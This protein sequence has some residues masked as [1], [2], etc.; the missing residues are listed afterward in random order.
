M[1][2]GETVLENIKRI[3]KAI[4][5]IEKNLTKKIELKEIASESALSEYHFHRLFHIV[6]GEA[7]G[8]YIRKRRL[9]QAAKSLSK[10]NKR[11]IDVA[12]DYGY[13]SSD[14][15]SRAFTKQFGFNPKD[16]K[17]NSSLLI[18]FP[19]PELTL[20][21]LN[22]INQGVSMEPKIIEKPEMKLVGVV[23]YGDNKSDEIP[24]F[25]NNHFSEVSSIGSRIDKNGCFGFCFHN[26]DYIKKGLFH[27]MP[28]VEVEN[29]DD[30][31][32]TAVAK[33]VPAHKYAVFTHT[34]DAEKL[35]ETY[36][37]IYGTWFPHKK[38]KKNES[39]DFEYYT[40]DEKGKSII[41]LHIPI[42]DK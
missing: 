8:S 23:Y 26:T 6:V 15:F 29:F 7:P 19:K 18:R 22:H 3:Y 37:Y 32:I 34:K 31:P 1:V 5:F 30:I 14:A 21:N 41:E 38:Y 39:F 36:E 33:T 4:D 27:Y 35:G 11:V 28:A 12:F 20:K 40:E 9:Y 16:Y 24:E 10:S 42:L 2:D 13:Q 25:W 17:N